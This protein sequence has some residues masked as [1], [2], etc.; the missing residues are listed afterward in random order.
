MVITIGLGARASTPQVPWPP[1]MGGGGAMGLAPDQVVTGAPTG[2]E[3]LLFLLPYPAHNTFKK[4][5]LEHRVLCKPV[6]SPGGA[7]CQSKPLRPSPR[8]ARLSGC[9]ESIYLAPLTPSL[10]F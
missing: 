10:T 6:L 1:W 4:P 3:S 2:Q 5:I 7:S 8:C 9:P